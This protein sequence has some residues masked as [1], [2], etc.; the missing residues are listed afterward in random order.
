MR[1]DPIATWFT[2][3]TERKLP[4]HQT[5]CGMKRPKWWAHYVHLHGNKLRQ[6]PPLNLLQFTSCGQLMLIQTCTHTHTTLKLNL[7]HPKMNMDIQ[8]WR[9]MESTAIISMCTLL[10]NIPKMSQELQKLLMSSYL[11]L[12]CCHAHKRDASNCIAYVFGILFKFHLLIAGSV[13]LFLLKACRK[14]SKYAS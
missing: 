5:V 6:W 4:P 2:K 10:A 1:Q 7:Q 8:T 12:C 14:R 13:Q 9:P 11:G 3:P